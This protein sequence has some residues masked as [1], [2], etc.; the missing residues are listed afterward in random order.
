M[1][2]ENTASVK[3]L[4]SSD[5]WYGVTYAQDKPVVVAALAKLTEEGKYPDGMWK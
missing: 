2:K 4:T 1:L 5:K 3:V